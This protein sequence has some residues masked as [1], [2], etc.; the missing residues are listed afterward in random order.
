M[1]HIHLQLTAQSYA[2]LFRSPII[3]NGAYSQGCVEHETY[4]C[5]PDSL[6]G[7]GIYTP[8]PQFKTRVG[9]SFT[10]RGN[11]HLCWHLLLEPLSVKLLPRACQEEDHIQCPLPTWLRGKPHLMRAPQYWSHAA[12]Q[13]PSQLSVKSGFMLQEVLWPTKVLGTGL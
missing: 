7:C 2:Y 13:V 1:T 12:P 10:S 8:S 9:Y 11:A 6:R 5:Q 3:V 4:K